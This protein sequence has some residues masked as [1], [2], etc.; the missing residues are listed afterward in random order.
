MTELTVVENLHS[1]SKKPIESLH[2]ALMN[3][4][5]D[6]C[7]NKLVTQAEIVG[8]LDFVKADVMGVYEDGN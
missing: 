6:Y 5:N 1:E 3:V 7:E 2:D 8:T 4:I